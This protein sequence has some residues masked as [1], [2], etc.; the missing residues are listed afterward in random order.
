MPII[1]EP[2]RTPEEGITAKVRKFI[3]IKNQL[4]DL[5]KEESALK[6]ELSELVD[7]TGDVDDKG[8]KWIY[9][10]V[11]VEGYKA[12][13]RQRRVSQSIDSE[14]VARILSEKKLKDRC[15]KL[16]PVLDENE[17][18]TCM[19]EKLLTEEEVDS[20]YPKSITW[21]FVPSKS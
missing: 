9:L 16:V 20:M 6:K 21:A 2:S 1:E 12:L 18:L 19:Y 14:T 5:S 8:H 17:I 13:Q 4:A 10:P 11:E 3:S 15:Y 7:S